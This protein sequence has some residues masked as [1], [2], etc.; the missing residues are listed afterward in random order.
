MT[1]RTSHLQR[2]EKAGSH[3]RRVAGLL[4]LAPA[5]L[6]SAS[7][8]HALQ[9]M[10]DD[11]MGHVT[12]EG[13]AIVLNDISLTMSP[14]SYIE[15]TG[16]DI[17]STNMPY[18]R[19]DLRWYG[20]SYTGA[21]GSS[22][23]AWSGVCTSGIMDLG[24]PIGGTIANLAPHDNP[25]LL[26]AF[27]YTGTLFNGTVNENRTV[28][29]LIFPTDHENYRFAFW[30]EMNVGT[31]TTRRGGTPGTNG[32]SAI[33]NG[34]NKIQIQ[35]VWNNI[36]QGGTVV[37]LFQHSDPADPT[38]GI[39][40]INYFSADIRMSVNQTL[41]SPDTLGQTPEFDDTEGLYIGDYR[42]FLPVGQLHYQSL[43]LDD[44]PSRSGDFQIKLTQLPDIAAIYND[45]YGRTFADDS[46]GGFDRTK[47]NTRGTYNNTHG[48]IRMGDWA[49]T[50]NTNIA[51]APPDFNTT[52]AP[53][54][55]MPTETAGCISDRPGC[56]KNTD[57]TTNDG[58]FFVAAPG[59][60]FTVYNV[61]PNF[62]W[63]GNVDAD[64]NSNAIGG[65][66][67]GGTN[68]RSVINLGDSRI[69]GLMIHAMT[70]KTLGAGG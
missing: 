7:L 66:A 14:T 10:G 63:D 32:T 34:S 35:N 6:L 67:G 11:A 9:E 17:T 19:G 30:G 65:G 29:D 53:I 70:L 60:S 48:W 46:T 38:M 49:P 27:D 62:M 23:Q 61:S 18:L 20:L 13:I 55:S 40:Y 36:N 50:N 47:Y 41:F 37:R 68:V 33:G 31:G 26:R 16:T 28:L 39:Q 12:G 43:I 2:F 15:L 4:A 59:E 51:Y 25:L 22:G 52:N 64:M 45:H 42:I 3:A 57:N 56:V 44:V 54:S 24:C 5:C 21:D 8:A 58:I 69:E 1:I